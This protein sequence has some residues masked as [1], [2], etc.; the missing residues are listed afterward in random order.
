[1]R[2]S[3]FEE[4]L[5]A[6]TQKWKKYSEKSVQKHITEVNKAEA[7]GDK[8]Y[9]EYLVSVRLALESGLAEDLDQ[10]LR[11]AQGEIEGCYG[12]SRDETRAEAGC[13]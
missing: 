13:D 11:K 6:L 9:F 8:I 3:T 12:V 1:M 10:L 4:K 2:L 5:N 7:Q